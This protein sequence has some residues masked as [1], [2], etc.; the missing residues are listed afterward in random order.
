MGHRPRSP[1]IYCLQGAT[2]DPGHVLPPIVP[3]QWSSD[4]VPLRRGDPPTRLTTS[5]VSL[6]L[7]HNLVYFDGCGREF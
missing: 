6:H 4:S 2:V 7:N 1:W 5:P 3:A